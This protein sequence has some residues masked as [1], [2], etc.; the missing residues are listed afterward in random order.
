LQRDGLFTYCITPPSTYM[1]ETVR[2]GRES[3]LAAI[4]N[5]AKNTTLRLLKRF[6]NMRK[7]DSVSMD[8]FLTEVKE[9]VDLLEELDLELPEPIVVYWTV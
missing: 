3:A 8:S 2:L 1:S 4:N 7:S 5:N 9:V 6:F